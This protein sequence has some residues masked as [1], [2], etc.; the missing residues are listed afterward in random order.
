M[1]LVLRSPPGMGVGKEIKH[2]DIGIVVPLREEFRYVTEVAP[3][4]ESIP[5]EGAYFYRLDFGATSA[6]CCVVDQMGPLPAL[7]A[8]IRLLGFAEVNL[9]VVLGIAGALDSDVA[10]G[11]VVVAREINEFQ[12]N[13]KAESV[14]E[15]YEVRYSGRHW[16]LDFGIREALSNFEFSAK[17]C[18]DSWQTAANDHYRDLGS[19]EGK[20]A[21][22]PQMHL[23][24]IASGNVVA[25][26]SAFVAEVKRIDRK[27]LA[28]DM[29]AAGI[30]PA[31]GDRI[32]PLPCLA[33]RGVSDRA[34]EQK[35]S[36]D[37]DGK[38]AWRRYAARNAAAFLRELLKWDGF[39]KAAGLD[40]TVAGTEDIA[41]QLATRLKAQVAGPWLI[42]VTFG[43]YVH[44]P[45]LVEGEAVPM[46]LTRLRVADGKVRS[47]LDAA[48]KIRDSLLLDGQL[49][50]AASGLQNL[51]DGFCTQ[52]NSPKAL[53]LLR[54]FDQ[55]VMAV[56]FPEDE[57]KEAEAVLLQ[58]EKIEEEQ[59]YEAVAEFLKEF[60]NSDA[61][62][63]E[64]YVD[65]LAA[66]KRWSEISDLVG[67]IDPSELSR[68]EIEHGFSAYAEL[69]MNDRAKLL[70]TQH[71]KLFEDTGAKMF[72][73][74]LSRRYQGISENEG[75]EA[76]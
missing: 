37:S 22:R 47:L 48:E 10:L 17:S 62:V 57:N 35:A 21:G 58:A 6:I 42:G 69:G 14:D 26:S 20:D 72:R 16:T 68:L 12:A 65:A 73:R 76:R 27:F 25:A 45:A 38:K 75:G 43:V 29:E 33:I 56:L 15:G 30:A 32:H 49:P 19:P 8:A 44:G 64:R 5:H 52:L 74:E 59:G 67:T 2:F 1:A 13:S 66:S 3:Q 7:Q 39:R 71:K 28:I 18:F 55:V 31:A 34:D 61:R 63:R 41:K 60:V 70:M 11:D 24:S 40:S 23:G 50:E 51:A 36:L 46:D 54:G 9:L 53:S 4:L